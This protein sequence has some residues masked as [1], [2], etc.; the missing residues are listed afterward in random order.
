[1]VQPWDYFQAPGSLPALAVESYL[2][3][4]ENG[5]GNPSSSPNQMYAQPWFTGDVALNVAS[6]GL[7]VTGVGTAKVDL[8]VYEAQ[9][10]RDIY[11]GN[12]I[13][14]STLA[15]EIVYGSTGAVLRS[16]SLPMSF[17]AGKLYWFVTN[18]DGGSGSHI[19]A[20]AGQALNYPAGVLGWIPASAVG[21]TMLRVARTYALGMPATFP[22]GAAPVGGAGFVVATAPAIIVV[23]QP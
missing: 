23:P 14:Q 4:T 7:R 5:T 17:A 10:E 9:S 13:W 18:T 19:C 8:A 22:A 21:A 6:F 20:F 3:R 11:P 12:R 15:N 16:V 1:M 2:S